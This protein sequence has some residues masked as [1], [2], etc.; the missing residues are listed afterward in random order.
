MA[1]PGDLPFLTTF[2]VG[3][4]LLH[5]HPL[6]K[7]ETPVPLPG[8]SSGNSTSGG[9]ASRGRS[10]LPEPKELL[11]LMLAGPHEMPLGPRK[12]SAAPHG[13]GDAGASPGATSKQNQEA[14]PVA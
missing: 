3:A 5:S 11:W 9:E 7:P 1:P 4:E 12:R 13:A 10:R 14:A 2:P 6:C 8:N